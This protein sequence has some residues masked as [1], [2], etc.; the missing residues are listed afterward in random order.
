MDTNQVPKKCTQLKHFFFL[1]RCGP[2]RAMASSFTR[3]LDNTQRRNT[4]GRTPLDERSARRRDLYLTRHNT[5]NR[6]ISMP[7]VGFEPTIAAGER[8]QTYALDRAVTGTGQLKHS[9]LKY[10][11]NTPMQVLIALNTSIQVLIALNT[12]IQVLIAL[13]TPIQVLIALITPIQVLI[14][15]IVIIKIL[16]LYNNRIQ[17]KRSSAATCSSW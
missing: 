10:K 17:H 6:Q 9:L 12:P 1:W 13:N 5:H 8:P 7:P 2:T 15:L 11:R 16:K 3:F 4:V 14:A